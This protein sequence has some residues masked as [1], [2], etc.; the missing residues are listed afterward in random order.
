MTSD[1]FEVALQLEQ[2]R[3]GRSGNITGPIWLQ[4]RGIQFPSAA[5][6]D[7]PV[8]ILGWWLEHVTS[9]RYG[10]NEARCVFMDGPYEFIIANR[11]AGLVHIQLIDRHV[12]GHPPIE[13]LIIP[14]LALQTSLC[15]AANAVVAECAHRDWKS[16]DVSTLQAC[17]SALS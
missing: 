3:Q 17:L 10:K 15:V 4:I 16:K 12:E 1:Q 8:V 13:G 5:W 9:L 2:F 7:F 6:S 11:S 14:Y